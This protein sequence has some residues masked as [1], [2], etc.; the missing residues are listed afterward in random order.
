VIILTSNVGAAQTQAERTGV[1][2]FGSDVDGSAVGEKQYEEMKENVTK[3][4]KEKFRPE[5]L[6]RMDDIIVFHR[7][8]E[9]EIAQIGGKMLSALAKRLYEQRGIVLS[10]TEDAKRALVQE[11]YDSQYGAR[12]LKRVIR[13]RV[14]D[15]LS[16]EILLGKIKNGQ[17]VL[18]GYDGKEITVEVR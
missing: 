9:S 4:L 10:V 7:L 13:K 18:V 12:P 8:S 17:K 16:E 15:R 14:E 5:L 11:G 6:N 3:A 1:Y 2:G